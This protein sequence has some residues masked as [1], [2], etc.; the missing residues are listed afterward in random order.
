VVQLFRQEAL[1]RQGNR[2]YGNVSLNQPIVFAWLA[3]LL[4]IIV[5]VSSI[6]LATGTYKRKAGVI[7]VLQSQKGVVQ[8][9]TKNSGKLQQLLVQEG[10]NV[11]EGQTLFVLSNEQYFDEK[12]DLNGSLEKEVA[13]ILSNLEQEKNSQK[14][15]YAIQSRE[16]EKRIIE[17]QRQLE[18][19]KRQKQTVLERIELADSL[20]K[21]T[22]SLLDQGVLSKLELINR[23]DTLLSLKQ[24]SQSLE[25][26]EISYDLELQ[27]QQSL[28][29][30]LPIDYQARVSEIANVQSERRNQ[31][32]RFKYDKNHVIKS[33]VDGVVTGISLKLDQYVTAGQRLVSILPEAS[34]LEVIAYVPTREIAFIAENQNALMR[35]DA[36]PYQRFGVHQGKVFEVSKNV[37]LPD[38]VSQLT[39]NEPSYRIKI[40]LPAQTIHAYGEDLPL[41]VGM[42]L[43]ADIVTEERSLLKWVFDPIFSLKGKL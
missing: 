16:V 30:Q 7:G 9:H 41:R 15:R 42:T 17:L 25:T 14:E 35:F 24:Q 23:K 40:R 3:G 37:L 2:L 31:I 33:P 4:V 22:E 21:Q 18:L 34:E 6:F 29:Q 5:V 10:Q 32:T 19:V 12:Q 20:V 26:Q 38:E 27:Q 1:N 43:E 28:K 8:L 13:D 36:F 11:T 39:I